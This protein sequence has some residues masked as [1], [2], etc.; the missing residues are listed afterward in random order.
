MTRPI[1]KFSTIFFT[2][3]LNFNV[4]NLSAQKCF[5][6]EPITADQAKKIIGNWKGSYYHSGKEISFMMK[7]TKD[8]NQQITCDINEPPLEGKIDAETVWFCGSGEFHLERTVGRKTYSFQ[9]VPVNNTIEGWL[10]VKE[11]D[12]ILEQE[13]F[14]INKY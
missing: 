9:G 14:A 4:Q 8:N 12:K 1:A 6:P 5:K 3:I 2:V 10:R 13:K 11:G 7:I